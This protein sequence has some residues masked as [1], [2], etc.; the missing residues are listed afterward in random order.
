M[1][2]MRV[3]L[4]LLAAFA[5]AASAAGPG[6]AAAQQAA[7]RG[8]A[9]GTAPGAAPEAAAAQVG[10]DTLQR[11]AASGRILLGHR[12]GARPFSFIDA[13]G[14]AAGYSVDLCHHIAEEV[15]LELGRPDLEVVHVPVTA[16]DR[17]EKLKSGEIDL[18]CG[19]TTSTLERQREFDFSSLTFVTGGTLL[20][21]ADSEVTGVA[22]LGGRR[23][24]V[25]PDT[26]TRPAL[27][28]ALQRNGVTAEIVPV[29][30]HAAGL[31]ALESGQIDAYAADRIVL[32]GLAQSAAAPEA[33]VLSASLFSHEPFALA[34]RPGDH[35]FRTLVNR[36]LSRIYG[37]GAIAE[38]YDR[39]F[40]SM[41][42]R[43]SQVLRALYILQTFPD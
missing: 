7:A 20:A 5:I 31:Q 25:I 32:I 35:A 42:A 28:Q 36:T 18:L 29:E 34:M 19:A 9:Q 24:G 3:V 8:A 4:P 6:P 2:R 14:F 23:V 38:I 39:W 43:P 11:I 15:K 27:E 41:G 40:G 33:L 30:D 21:R 22:D 16:E 12:R 17:F 10:S 37:S 26:T 13:D 1:P